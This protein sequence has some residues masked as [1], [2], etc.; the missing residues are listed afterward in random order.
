MLRKQDS[1]MF[2]S[3]VITY[4]HTMLKY[5]TIKLEENTGK[6]SLT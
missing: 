3:E 5:D 4:P 2:V 6:H 1:Y